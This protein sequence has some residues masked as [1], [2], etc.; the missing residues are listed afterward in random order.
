M[1]DSQCCGL[2]PCRYLEGGVA[3]GFKKVEK[4]KYEPRLLHVKGRRNIRVWQVCLENERLPLSLNGPHTS[5]R[6]S[7]F[8]CHNC[9][10]LGE[11][12]VVWEF[13]MC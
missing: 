1:Y 5:P 11:M 9:T 3:S 12:L 6:D 4:D 13:C 7:V 8:P 10:S 2:V